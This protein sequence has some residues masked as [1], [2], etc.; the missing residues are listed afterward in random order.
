MLKNRK[1]IEY[2][3]DHMKNISELI[4]IGKAVDR[5]TSGASEE[6]ENIL[7]EAY[8]ETAEEQG[9]ERLE[10]MLGIDGRGKSLESRRKNIL[11]LLMG[12]APYTFVS[13]NNKLDSVW[14]KNNVSIQYGSEPYVIDVNIGLGAKN[15]KDVIKKYLDI[16]VP[17]NVQI[18]CNII[19]NT[20]NG[21]GKYTHE[22]LHSYSHKILKEG[23]IL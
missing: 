1:Y 7:E 5:F 16:V 20:H 17:A 13:V 11:M 12:D 14:G 23:I 19:Y 21:I 8:V 3:P 9:L 4:E 18:N 22:R 6:I 15:Y 2:I 10:N